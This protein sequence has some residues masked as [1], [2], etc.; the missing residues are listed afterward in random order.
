MTI[1]FSA[2]WLIES[3]YEISFYLPESLISKKKYSISF[4]MFVHVLDSIKKIILAFVNMSGCLN[5]RII[6]WI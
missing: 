3:I 1:C 2:Y 5:L 4:S 6:L